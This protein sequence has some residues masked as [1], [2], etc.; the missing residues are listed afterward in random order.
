M[1][2][3]IAVTSAHSLN[4][5]SAITPELLK[6]IAASDFVAMVLSGRGR[7]S[8]MYELG[9][10]R[11]LGKAAFIVLTEGA[12][13][14]EISGAYLRAVEDRRV[15]DAGDDLDRFLR[16]AKAPPA[17][18]AD[19][20]DARTV[21]LSWAS[22]ELQHLRS[23]AAGNS[24]AEIFEDLIK[25][26]FESAGADVTATDAPRNEPQVDFVVW[27]NEIAF[28]A[29]GPVL[30]ECKLLRGGSGSVIKNAEAYVKRL[31]R[32]VEASDASLALLVFDHD[33]SH[34]PP[35]LFETPQVLSFSA[36]DLISTLEGGRLEKEIL[37]R[38]R[39]AAFVRGDA[40]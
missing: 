17:I 39:R 5:G 23:G 29:G 37:K 27:L 22:R 2:R 32:A 18:L 36:E 10:A 16:N 19:V 40:E 30:V 31:T 35:S 1:A 6:L 12:A 38:R 14:N 3:G 11:S 15:A 28:E 13:P 26:I 7:D 33:R 24:R 20:P 34:T 4:V 25:R 21:D 8:I 9:I